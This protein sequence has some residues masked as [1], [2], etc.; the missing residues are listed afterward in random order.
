MFCLAVILAG[1]QSTERI[2]NQ[3]LAYIYDSKTAALQPEFRVR[4]ENDTVSLIDMH[5]RSSDLL[6]IFNPASGYHSAE[7]RLRYEVYGQLE[8]RIVLD[9]AVVL[10]KDSVPEVTDRSIETTLRLRTSRSPVALLKLDM[11]D[12]KANNRYRRYI[13]IDRSDRNAAQFFS[14]QNAEGHAK[15][16][17]HLE[18]N[19][20]VVITHA[21]G[22]THA[23]VRYYKGE[24]PLPRPP[25]S[26]EDPT[27]FNY[28]ADSIFPLE[29]GA[30]IGLE[31]EGMYHIQVSDTGRSGLTLFRFRDGFPKVRNV[32]DL[33]APL[34]YI[35]SSQ[36]F[37]KLTSADFPKAEV[38]RF[39]LSLA[40]N[41]D[42]ARILIEKFYGRVQDAN[43]YFTSFTEG[44]RTDRGMIYL[45][46][47]PPTTVYK[48]SSAEQWTY[49]E[50]SN[51]SSVSFTFVK[52]NNPFTDND[53]RLERSQLYKSSWF[54]AVDMWRQGR[55][56]L[57]N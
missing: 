11:V 7:F 50:P 33:I 45:I 32:D 40:G 9:S 36:E 47:G 56:Y 16:N 29:L 15:F 55:I 37:K 35:N 39:W 53:F 18:T 26:M 6:Y 1:C 57:E 17:S 54:R 4:H 25:F 42:R 43:R 14:V 8:S 28:K 44:W 22:Y 31:K 10:F 23:K 24:F 13:N 49:G 30:P 12:L 46:F 19:E 20:K 5:L 48:G 27:P 38:D 21:K 52:V 34:R 2:V 3:N 51:P 41:S